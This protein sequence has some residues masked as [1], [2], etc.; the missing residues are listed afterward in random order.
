MLEIMLAGVKKDTGPALP[1]ALGPGPQ[2]LVGGDANAG[3]FG[4][5]T[6]AELIAGNTLATAMGL[7]AGSVQNAAEPWLKFIID[8]VIIYYSKKPYKHTVS[9]NNLNAAGIASGTR[10]FVI[11]DNRY[12]VGL[13]YGRNPETLAG[14]SSGNDTP[15]GYNS[16]WNR[17]MYKITTNNPASEAPGPNWAN[18]TDN[19]LVVHNAGGNGNL[20]W[21]T[22]LP[23]A[24]MPGTRVL[25]GNG[26]V[27]YI[28][29]DPTD[30]TSVAYGWRPRLQLIPPV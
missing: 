25:R 15:S 7:N 20:C 8:G 3:F 14:F 10:E 19:E 29:G 12:K 1:D 28:G 26:G 13:P 6:V 16:E 17:L 30:W 24:S 9:W 5:T 23:H 27:Q 11:G 21:C 22:E 18:Y 2:E 4:E